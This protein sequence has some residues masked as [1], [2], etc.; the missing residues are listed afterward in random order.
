MK[1]SDMNLT[2]EEKSK[3]LEELLAERVVMQTESL[4]MLLGIT[5]NIMSIVDN[6]S[7]LPSKELLKAL[8]TVK[9]EIESLQKIIDVEPKK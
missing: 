8:N 1:L 7:K 5:E 2:P 6:L 4:V 9:P 3:L